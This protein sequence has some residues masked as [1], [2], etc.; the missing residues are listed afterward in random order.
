MDT[1]A[2]GATGTRYSHYAARVPWVEHK[3][4]SRVRKALG[5]VHGVA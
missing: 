1:L 5:H 3:L 4:A 2:T